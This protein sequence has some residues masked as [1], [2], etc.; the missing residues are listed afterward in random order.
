MD[1]YLPLKRGAWLADF[2]NN[3]QMDLKCWTR[4]LSIYDHGLRAIGY[5]DDLRRRK[6]RFVAIF[7]FRGE[8]KEEHYLYGGGDIENGVLARLLRRDAEDFYQELGLWMPDIGAAYALQIMQGQNTLHNM[9]DQQNT[10]GL[11]RLLQRQTPFAEEILANPNLESFMEKTEEVYRRGL[12]TLH[13]NDPRLSLSGFDRD[14]HHVVK[15]ALRSDPTH[16]VLEDRSVFRVRL[17]T[18]AEKTRGPDNCRW[19]LAFDMDNAAIMSINEQLIEL[20]AIYEVTNQYSDI[21]MALEE[22]TDWLHKNN[23]IDGREVE[24]VEWINGTSQ[25]PHY[26]GPETMWPY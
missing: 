19:F 5:A 13:N 3:R 17:S 20:Y 6:L 24:I 8:I 2:L 23:Y 21:R 10:S 14:L 11:Y 15:S 18:V 16:M 25:H 1:Y 9:Q 22:A 12:L 4:L 26:P 7:L